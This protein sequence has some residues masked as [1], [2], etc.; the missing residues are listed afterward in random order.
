MANRY[1]VLGRGGENV[2]ELN[3]SNSCTQESQEG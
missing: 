1:R 2:L 3:S